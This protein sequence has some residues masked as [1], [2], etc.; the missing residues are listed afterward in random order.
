MGIAWLLWSASTQIIAPDTVPL[1]DYQRAALEEPALHIVNLTA[2]DGEV[3]FLAVSPRQENPSKRGR[4][5]RD[6]LIEQQID[7]VAYGETQATLVLLH[8]RRGRKES[9]LR[10]AERFTAIGFRCLIPDL[11]AHGESRRDQLNYGSSSFEGKLAHEVVEASRESLGWPQAN[12]ALGLWGMSMGG[13]FATAAAAQPEDSWDALMIVCSFDQLDGVL[14]DKLGPLA[15]PVEAL[16]KLRSGFDMADAAPVTWAA[17]CSRIPVFMAHGDQDPLI[18]LSRGEKL[19]RAFPHTDK[20]WLTVTGA[21]HHNI[22]ITDQPVF[23]AMGQWLL[24]NCKPS[25]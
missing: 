10:V 20:A 22:L 14:S 12:E 19:F 11:P 5:L 7:L 16:V 6:Q 3:P 23:A 21:N 24:E 1:G 17:K 2:L 15:G 13:A 8:G 18:D 9:L 25:N 4:T